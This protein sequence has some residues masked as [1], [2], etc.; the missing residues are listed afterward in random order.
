MK[1]V[2]FPQDALEAQRRSIGEDP[3]TGVAPVE[4][5]VSGVEWAPPS[6]KF[7]DVVMLDPLPTERAG[8]R[9]GRI[10]CEAL[11]WMLRKLVNERWWEEEPEVLVEELT[12]R[13]HYVDAAGFGKL[14]AVQALLRAP[15]NNSPFYRRWYTYLFMTANLLGRPIRWGELTVPSP[16]ECAL[17]MHIATE[18]RPLPF[19]DEVLGTI[20]SCCIHHGLWC[21]PDILGQAQDAV[22]HHLTYQLIP[23]GEPEVGEVRSRVLAAKGE[24]KSS[25]D[26]LDPDEHG[27]DE[28][29]ELL[30]AQAIRVLDTQERLESLHEHGQTAQD[31]ILDKYITSETP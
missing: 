26:M 21:L 20:A 19:H 7:P 23:L 11:Y 14:L 24:G 25:G 29:E 16:L 10:P 6:E 22:Y 17:S 15:D 5:Y 13:G 28:R 27:I 2:I 1:T 18:L 31:L 12:R 30:R 9:L 3:F 8:K 4:E